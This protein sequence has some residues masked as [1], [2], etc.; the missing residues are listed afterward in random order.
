MITRETRSFPE[1]SFRISA[2][3]FLEEFHHSSGVRLLV[4]SQKAIAIVDILVVRHFSPLLTPGQ[5]TRCEKCDFI[6]VSCTGEVCHDILLLLTFSL[7]IFLFLSVIVRSPLA[8]CQRCISSLFSF[9]P[10][11]L[12]GRQAS[13][14]F[15]IMFWRRDE[16]N[17]LLQ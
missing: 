12:P 8:Q 17:V 9:P 15:T 5:K 7:I 6:N 3:V 10:F 13:E 11:F 14:I 4:A 16:S 2:L 1:G